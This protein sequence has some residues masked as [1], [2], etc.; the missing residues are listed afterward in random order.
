MIALRN[1]LPRITGSDL[2]NNCASNSVFSCE[3]ALPFSLRIPTPDSEHV[4]FCELCQR[5]FATSFQKF[6]VSSGA[7]LIASLQSVWSRSRAVGVAL[8]GIVPSSFDA[9]VSIALE[10]SEVEVFWI[11]ALTIVAGMCN[12]L[13]SIMKA[14]FT[15][16]FHVVA[17]LI[18]QAVG[19]HNLSAPSYGPV[20]TVIQTFGPLPA[21]ICK[22]NGYVSP[23]I[24]GCI[25]IMSNPH[26]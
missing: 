12:K 20:S 19:F 11:T 4:A 3:G 7:I 25:P 14:W 16:Q 22:S 17:K 8:R 13:A 18:C 26:D 21:F 24:L 5:M 2:P 6:R 15:R 23:K 10:R 9:L 1:V